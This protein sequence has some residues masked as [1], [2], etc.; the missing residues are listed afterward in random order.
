MNGG[1][2]LV[3]LFPIPSRENYLNLECLEYL[4]PALASGS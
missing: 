1:G 3:Y 4:E 2:S